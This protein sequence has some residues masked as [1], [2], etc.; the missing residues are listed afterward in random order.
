[1]HEAC[2]GGWQPTLP[3]LAGD[4]AAWCA[5]KWTATMGSRNGP[6]KDLM[7]VLSKDTASSCVFNA[8]LVNCATFWLQ[9]F[10]DPTQNVSSYYTKQCLCCRSVLLWEHRP[11][12]H[13][14]I[15]KFGH[16]VRRC[17]KMAWFETQFDTTTKLATL[18]T[19]VQTFVRLVHGIATIPYPG[20]RKR[21]WLFHETRDLVVGW[22]RCVVIDKKHKQRFR[23]IRVCYLWVSLTSLLTK[24]TQLLAQYFHIIY[25]LIEMAT[26][27]YNIFVG[28]EHSRHL[29]QTLHNFGPN[30]RKFCQHPYQHL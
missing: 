14:F 10:V 17:C 18:G 2:I 22:P 12:I 21:W 13:M 28:M 24:P 4:N 26:L 29:R 6:P 3:N 15:W 16:V 19:D 27:R 8:C 30:S 7:K 5:Q 11:D 9:M 1:M 23:K 20:Q 25:N